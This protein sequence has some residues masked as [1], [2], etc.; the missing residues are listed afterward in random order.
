MSWW[1]QISSKEIPEPQDEKH[2]SPSM[3]PATGSRPLFYVLLDCQS[4]WLTPFVQKERRWTTS[5]P[6][7]INL[8]AW[9]RPRRPLSLNYFPTEPP[10]HHAKHS[11]TVLSATAAHFKSDPTPKHNSLIRSSWSRISIEPLSTDGRI[12]ITRLDMFWKTQLYL[13]SL[14]AS[15]HPSNDICSQAH[16]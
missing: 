7:Y 5:S 4:K 16:R 12:N 9:V 1:K 8:G 11:V 14:Y 3:P 2:D 13:C 15:P 10:R 6:T